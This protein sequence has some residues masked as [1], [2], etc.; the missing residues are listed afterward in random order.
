MFAFL[1]FG[2]Q[3]P[4][5]VLAL[6]SRC[7][8]PLRRA[9]DRV[10]LAVQARHPD[11]ITTAGCSPC[12]T[13]RGVRR[14]VTKLLK[15]VRQERHARGGSHFK[16]FD[17]PVLL[18]WGTEKDFFHVEYAERLARDFPNARLERIDDCYTFVPEDQPGAARRAD[19]RVRAGA[20]AGDRRA[21]ALALVA[22]AFGDRVGE[23][24]CP[25]PAVDAGHDAGRHAEQPAR[26]SAATRRHVDLGAV[27]LDAL[28]HGP[29]T[30]LGRRVPT[31]RGSFDPLS[32]NMPA[33][34]MNPGKTVVTPTPVPRS[35]SC[36]A[37]PNP[38]RPNFVAL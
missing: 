2:A 23:R 5:F 15:G 36:S 14:D 21:A 17:K 8:S 31:P 25:Q 7:A 27:L 4:G 29:A 20:G 18:A 32:A 37:K 3:L 1:L 9:A 12:W 35:S 34:R 10:R 6:A 11:D 38:R 13:T 19:R 16:E 26:P 28:D 33:S 22:L 24:V 30:S